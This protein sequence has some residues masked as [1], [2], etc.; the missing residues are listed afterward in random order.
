MSLRLNLYIEKS[1]SVYKEARSKLYRMFDGLSDASKTRLFEA[2]DIVGTVGRKVYKEPKVYD[3]TNYKTAPSFSSFTPRQP[4]VAI[5]PKAREVDLN[6]KI[7]SRGPRDF[8]KKP[9]LRPPQQVNRGMLTGSF[10]IIDKFN[11]K[12][13]P[14][15]TRG[16]HSIHIDESP[17]HTQPH[18][19]NA[20]RSINMPL[21]STDGAIFKHEVYESLDPHARTLEGKMGTSKARGHI[22]ASDE[23]PQSVQH[24]KTEIHKNI[25][26]LG[27]NGVLDVM[28]HNS[29]GVLGKEHNNHVGFSYVPNVAEL[30]HYRDSSGEAAFIRSVAGE[31]RN[32]GK[33]S[34][35][36]IKTLENHPAGNFNL[37]PFMRAP[38][39]KTTNK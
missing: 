4:H 36:Q 35:R 37:T 30:S 39:G 9:T 3:L 38:E 31:P 8:S 33:F 5:S 16:L 28:S 6:T 22:T 34:R 20:K 10:N 1:A 14:P 19:N 29:L 12:I 11:S 21:Y 23:L 2:D 32:A 13:K 27:R 7:N 26:E 18:F 15:H 17:I 24:K 25:E